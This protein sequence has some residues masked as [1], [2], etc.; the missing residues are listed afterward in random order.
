MDLDCLDLVDF[1]LNN[2][3]LNKSFYLR[4]YSEC[5]QLTEGVKTLCVCVQGESETRHTTDDSKNVCMDVQHVLTAYEK[6][7]KYLVS[8][9][10][11]P[12]R[13]CVLH[14]GGNLWTFEF[15]DRLLVL[16]QLSVCEVRQR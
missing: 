1:Y 13:L 3:A 9:S 11:R 5:L 16:K 4:I 7:L 14:V 2:P 12:L 15:K 8:P 6:Y 10:F